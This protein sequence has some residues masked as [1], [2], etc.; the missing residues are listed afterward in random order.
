M[1]YIGRKQKEKEDSFLLSVAN[2]SAGNG[3]QAPNKE[4]QV[5]LILETISLFSNQKKKKIFPMQGQNIVVSV[6]LSWQIFLKKKYQNMN[7]S[8]GLG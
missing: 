2:R 3:K 1:G 8:F 6:C 7:S 5:H 4:K